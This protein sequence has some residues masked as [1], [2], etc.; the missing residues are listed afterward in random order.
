MAGVGEPLTSLP[1]EVLAALSQHLEGCYPREGCGVLLRT[2]AGAWRARPLRNA[3]G[4]RTAYAFAPS[5][6]L[7]VLQDADARA[8]RV[9]G[10]FHSHVDTPADFS[11]EDRR[12]AMTDEGPVWAEVF[13]LVVAVRA[14]RAVE[15]RRFDWNGREF[16]GRELPWP[17]A[18][19]QIP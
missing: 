4:A 18:P 19:T 13:H 7:A 12:Q 15:A 3:L 5:E 2:A 1:P 11:D 8:E 17:P 10:V 14:G 9:A 16:A 6:W